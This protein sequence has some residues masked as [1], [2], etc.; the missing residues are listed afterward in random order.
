MDISAC[1]NLAKTEVFPLSNC[2]KSII[3]DLGSFEVCHFQV[4]LMS[5]F[6]QENSNIVQMT[7]DFP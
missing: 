5:S 3:L 7:F 1:Q 4:I 6:W 2:Q